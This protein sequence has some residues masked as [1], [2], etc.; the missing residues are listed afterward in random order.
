MQTYDFDHVHLKA[1]D[2]EKTAA[3]YC[4]KLG[5]KK[6]FEGC[7]CGSKVIY[8]EIN[9]MTFIVFGHLNDDHEPIP[10]SLNTR[11]GLDHFGF[12]VADIDTAIK[13]LQAKQVIIIKEPAT[14][15]PG[16]R[17]AYIE[18]PDQVRIELTQRD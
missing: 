14:V 1:N 9:G 2:V 15:R 16:V 18:A 17:M 4:E 10:A 7:F 5:G 12:E 13:E 11:F 6:V 8:V 3:W